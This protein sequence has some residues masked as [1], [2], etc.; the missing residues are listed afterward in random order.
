[1]KKGISLSELVKQ[2]PARFSDAYL[3]RGVPAVTGKRIMKI[4]ITGGRTLLEKQ[5]GPACGTV[6]STDTTDGYRILFS[7]GD[8]VHFRPSGNAPE[9]RCYTESDSLEKATSLA[10]QGIEWARRLPIDD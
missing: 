2:F 7:G 5:F 4:L 8:I 9:F 6:E 1:M 10:R 3:M